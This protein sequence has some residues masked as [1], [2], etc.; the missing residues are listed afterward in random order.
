MARGC[1][2]GRGKRERV[3]LAKAPK[4][5]TCTGEWVTIRSVMLVGLW[6][7]LEPLF[8]VY[9]LGKWRFVLGGTGWNHDGMQGLQCGSLLAMALCGVGHAYRCTP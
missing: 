3:R 7:S 9:R 1:G 2:F 5:R 6:G 4:A 8:H